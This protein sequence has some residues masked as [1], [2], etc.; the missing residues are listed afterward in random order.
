MNNEEEST[1]AQTAD[2]EPTAPQAA[3]EPAV[4]AVPQPPISIVMT[5]HNN[6]RELEANMPAL[7]A[8]DYPAGYEVIIVASKSDD[9]TDDLLERLTQAHANVRT[10]FIPDSSRYMS[11][12]KLG[13]TLGVK[14]ARHEWILLTEPQCVPVSAQWLSL[15][16]ARCEEG[17]DMVMGYS[18]YDDDATDYQRM[19]RA[20]AQ[21]RLLSETRRRAY[22]TEGHNLMFRRQM[23]LEGRGYD[24][25]TQFVRGEYDFLVNK[26]AQ[27]GNVAIETSP[28]ARLTEA[29]PTGKMWL[30]R[31]LYYMCTRRHLR[32]SLLHRL[33]FNVR[34]GAIH[35]WYVVLIA[36]YVV[37]AVMQE[38]VW[39]GVAIA[40]LLATVVVHALMMRRAMAEFTPDIN[41]LKA[42]FL[43]LGRAWHALYYKLKYMRADKYDFTTHKL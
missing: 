42:V 8:Q 14:A 23:F 32:R 12:K 17:I 20:L 1:I 39:M 33:P 21:R 35:L 40:A 3:T 30:N 34:Q 38:W 18:N 4:Q 13:I 10:T 5:V 41:P 9:G 15:M 27:R 6:A 25:N 26:Y 36:A 29:A 24:G 43:D 16:A 2:A 7:L 37:S 28:A 11:R 31:H 19:E 22:R